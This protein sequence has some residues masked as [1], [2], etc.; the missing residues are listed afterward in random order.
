MKNKFTLLAFVSL[1]LSSFFIYTAC[2]DETEIEDISSIQ[3]KIETLKA[4]VVN[5]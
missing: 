4:G 1:L 5:D 2:Q 3:E